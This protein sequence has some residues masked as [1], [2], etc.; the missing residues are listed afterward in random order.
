MVCQVVPHVSSQCR[1]EMFLDD[2][3]AARTSLVEGASLASHLNEYKIMFSYQMLM[4]MMM[5]GESKFM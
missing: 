1:E 2:D 4:I 3:V 5:T